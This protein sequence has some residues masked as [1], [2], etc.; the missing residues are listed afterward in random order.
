LTCYII[1]IKTVKCLISVIEL[2]GGNGMIFQDGA[3]ITEAAVG[4]AKYESYEIAGEYV[5]VKWPEAKKGTVK[6]DR[7]PPDVTE[8]K[9]GEIVKNF[10]R[11][12]KNFSEKEALRFVHKYGLLADN[13]PGY[14][15]KTNFIRKEAEEFLRLV[16][17]YDQIRNKDYAT[18][19]RRITYESA[20]TPGMAT[21]ILAGTPPPQDKY[22]MAIIDG[23]PGPKHE[24][25]RKTKDAYLSDAFL[26]LA[27]SI[28]ERVKEVRL[29]FTT[30]TTD[31]GE[32]KII[33]AFRVNSPLE[34]IYLEFFLAIGR[35]AEVKQCQYKR[36][37]GFFFTDQKR[38]GTMYCSD[39][40]R[41]I[42]CYHRKKRTKK[43]GR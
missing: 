10:T 26:H 15:E 39:N 22:E 34:F 18:I 17:L 6:V 41:K 40:C 25:E 30:I 33:P 43:E 19:Q 23:R 2:K 31:E 20:V 36:C 21:A 13:K 9:P 24:I 42:A 38:A 37:G 8:E 29:T 11:L 27:W 4:W 7:L 12:A 35:Y 14:K 16:K 5:Q 3:L 32:Y 28:R 1:K